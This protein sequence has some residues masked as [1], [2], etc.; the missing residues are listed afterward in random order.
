MRRNASILVGLLWCVALLSL[1]VVG[2]L[3]TSRIDLMAVKNYGDRIQAHYLAVAGIEKAKALIYQN[4]HDRSR[5]AKNHSGD[6]YNSSDQ[7]REVAF[8]RGKFRVFRRGRQDE[9]GGIVYGIS[10]EESR[11]NVNSASTVQLTNIDR[12]TSEIAAAI[13]DWRG[14]GDAVTPGGANADYYLSLQPPYETATRG[15]ADDSR[16]LVGEGRHAGFVIWERQAREWFAAGSR[17]W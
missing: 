9:G 8:A 3:H 6:L 11:L 7:F 13:A 16:A 4:A 1:V 2:V 15:V 12:L 10:D 5:S 14:A 17:R